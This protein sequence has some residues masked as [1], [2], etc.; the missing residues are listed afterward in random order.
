M[1]T[2]KIINTM[3]LV[4]A[5]I[6]VIF[7]ITLSSAA[8]N[9]RKHDGSKVT[10]ELTSTKSEHKT[11]NYGGTEYYVFTNYQIKNNTD[12][13]IYYIE[14]K[15]FVYNSE[16]QKIGY[17]TSRIGTE[18]Q[19]SS[20]LELE[21]GESTDWECYF[22]TKNLESGE[23]ISEMYQSKFEELTYKSEVVYVKFADGE[24]WSSENR[25]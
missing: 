10:V 24:R 20:T 22:T 17:L 23:I 6:A 5:S 25:Y 21:T 11:L 3:L 18:Y 2:L 19:D 13:D 7:G 14:I 15:T 12:V 9:A 1:K 4:A 8:A 16:G